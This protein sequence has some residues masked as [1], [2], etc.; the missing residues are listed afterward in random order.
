MIS[1]D[2]FNIKNDT[3]SFRRIISSR[4]NIENDIN[5]LISVFRHASICNT[6]IQMTP[7]LS[8]SSCLNGFIYDVLNSV[9]SI[10]EKRERYFQLNCR[11]M[12]EH[13]ARITANK[14][15]NNNEFDLTVRRKDFDA[16]KKCTLNSNWNYLHS[17]YSNACHYIHSSPS[18]RLNFA[19][20]FNS[21]LAS[22][23]QT[24]QSKMIETLCKISS[25]LMKDVVFRYHQEISDIFF[26]NPADLK[27]IMGNSLYNHYKSLSDHH[28]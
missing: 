4:F 22:D 10:I 6:L 8:H 1:R 2:P 11:S 16:L 15:N 9:V 13:I 26:R 20:K 25:E 24:T 27:K 18:A 19:S 3:D 21:L 7:N 23:L 17:A 28:M 5:K 12:I 14:V